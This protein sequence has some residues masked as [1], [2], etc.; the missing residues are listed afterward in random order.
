MLIDKKTTKAINEGAKA[1]NA[2]AGAV[3]D[4]GE[5]VQVG[6]TQH[7]NSI[8]ALAGSISGA[9][10]G[11]IGGIGALESGFKDGAGALG[12][13]VKD[14]A[15]ALGAGVKEGAGALG[16]GF[17]DG[18]GALG[19]AIRDGASALALGFGGATVAV[20]SVKLGIEVYDRMYP[21]P[22]KLCQIA[23]NRKKASVLDCFA[24]AQGD[25]RTYGDWWNNTKPAMS[26]CEQLSKDYK[27]ML[28]AVSNNK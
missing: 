21:S 9:T 22:E 23:L 4:L 7:A 2:H 25:Y 14:G 6:F 19:S 10:F 15:G 13:G 12:V 16:V 8:T 20:S 11:I 24:R 17:K 1:I 18:A 26:E 27:R 3:V 28:D 5:N